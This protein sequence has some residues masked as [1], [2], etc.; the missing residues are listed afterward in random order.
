MYD[1]RFSQQLWRHIKSCVLVHIYQLYNGLWLSFIFPR[2][3]SSV[4]VYIYIFFFCFSLSISY[5]W[6]L[7]PSRAT[8]RP[9]SLLVP[10][11]LEQ[12][13]AA[14][15]LRNALRYARF[16]VVLQHRLLTKH[17]LR[18]PYYILDAQRYLRHQCL[19]PRKHSTVTHEI[20]VW[21]KW[22]PW[23]LGCNT[24]VI[25][26]L[27]RI[28]FT[29]TNFDCTRNA[30]SHNPSKITAEFSSSYPNLWRITDARDI[31]T[32]LYFIRLPGLFR[33]VSNG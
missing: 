6:W 4:C 33:C 2:Y 5:Q 31:G 19:P 20:E 3:P 27:G 15:C 29:W 17:L 24:S 32:F 12:P 30:M 22:L 10:L 11:F 26:P 8:P 9:P 28:P 18:L 13:N 25:V 7:L 21:C 14:I 1:S 16:S 23:Q